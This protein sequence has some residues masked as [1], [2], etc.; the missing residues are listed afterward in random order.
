LHEKIVIIDP[1]DVEWPVSLN[2]FDV[3]LERL[4]AYSQLDR[5]Q[6]I[7]SILELYDFVLGKLL[8]AEMTQK[9][10]VIFRYVTRLMLHIP[11]A[12]IHTLVDLMQ[13]DSEEGVCRAHRQAGRIGQTLLRDRVRVTRE[14][15]PDQVA[16]PAQAVGHSREPDV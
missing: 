7:N 4:D 16:S 12:T 11:D 15:C 6:L 8:A 1:K 14:F 3:G 13:P 10:S 9:Q 5:E 2:L